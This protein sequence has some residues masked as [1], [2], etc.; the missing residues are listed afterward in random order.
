MRRKL[1]KARST[2]LEKEEKPV[3]YNQ[4]TMKLRELGLWRK[5]KTDRRP[6]EAEVTQ[7]SLATQA[8][9]SHQRKTVA[10]HSAWSS[11]YRI[12]IPIAVF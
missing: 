1:G 11:P 6:A 2:R 8:N 5:G 3:S 7:W 9:K 4:P 10:S 12:Q